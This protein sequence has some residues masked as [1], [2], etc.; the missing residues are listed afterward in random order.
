MRLAVIVFGCVILSACAFTN[1]TVNPP[2]HVSTQLSGGDGRELVVHTPFA[3][4]RG[5]RQRCGMQK[6]SWN[7][8]T[9]SVICSSDPTGWLADLLVAELTAA[10]FKV[11]TEG[12]TSTPHGVTIDGVLLNFFVEPVI[13]FSTITIETDIHIKL[14]A[15]TKNG[16]NAERS[17]FVKGS[18]SAMTGMASN[19]QPSVDDA[20]K[21]AIKDMVAAILTLMNRYPELG[22]NNGPGDQMHITLL[23]RG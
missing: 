8:D 16:L 23:T 2:A 13:G 7:A 3:D 21:M 20:T 12:V 10:G 17:F 19:F 4:K 1:V 6:N 5:N 15:T 14:I 22:M 11:K 9:A 18:N